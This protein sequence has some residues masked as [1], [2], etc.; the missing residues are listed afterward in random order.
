VEEGTQLFN[1]EW[2]QHKAHFATARL[3]KVVLKKW[4][5]KGGWLQMVPTCGISTAW[6]RKTA[7]IYEYKLN[8][9]IL[10]FIV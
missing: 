10:I 9:K 6:G 3:L 8:T 7:I 4:L 2:L 5:R 1:I